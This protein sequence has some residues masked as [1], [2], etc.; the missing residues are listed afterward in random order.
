MSL[1]PDYE[2]AEVDTEQ[3]PPLSYYL[4]SQMAADERYAEWLDE[5]AS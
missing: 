3:E 4:E 5:R 2:P 1:N